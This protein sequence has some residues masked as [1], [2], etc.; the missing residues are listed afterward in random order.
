MKITFLG[1]GTSHGVPSLDCMIGQFA[2]CPRDVCRLA[3]FDPKHARTRSSILV[4]WNEHSVLIDVSADFRFQ[5]LRQQI[6]N[7][8]SV[9]ITHTHSDH[10]GGIPD[11]RSYT[12]NDP[13]PIYGSQES[14]SNLK[15]TFQYIFNPGTYVGGG[16]PR[17]NTCP[18]DNPFYLYEEKIT[19]ISVGHGSIG[20]C[21][22]YRIG[23]LSYIPDMK[24]IDR[25]QLRKLNGTEILILNCLRRERE[26]STHLILPQ[27]IELARSISPRRCYF[28][29]MCHDIHYEIDSVHLDPW[30]HFSYDGLI[31]EI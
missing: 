5:A 19:P 3:E 26:H 13:M 17:I 2:K 11:I 29:H 22:G 27:S 7:I 8:H 25:D 12:L 9:L 30:M 24:T 31:E 28:I 14:V 21:F 10:V 18:I 16:I 6:R 23:P 20:G 15:E 4:E 1:T